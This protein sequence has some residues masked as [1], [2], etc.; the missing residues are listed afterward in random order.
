MTV[1]DQLDVVPTGLAKHSGFAS[2]VAARPPN[3]SVCWEIDVERRTALLLRS[4][5]R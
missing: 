2:S 4:L 5:A 3:V 1:I